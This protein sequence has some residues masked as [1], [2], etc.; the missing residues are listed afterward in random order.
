MTSLSSPSR[1]ARPAVAVPT[2]VLWI[3][4]VLLGLL[5]TVLLASAVYFTF[6]APP[7]EGGVTT[8]VDWAV[9]VWAMVTAV[10]FLVVA[11]LLGNGTRRTLVIARALLVSHLVFGLVKVVFYAE[12]ES[13]TFIAVDL[14][15][16]A[17]LAIRRR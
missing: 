13:A 10:G 15:L 7:E 8:P 2:P 4:R 6:F 12:P 5:G 9:A 16:L 1:A 17:L 14:L 11:V 3:A